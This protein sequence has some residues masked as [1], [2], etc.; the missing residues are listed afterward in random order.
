MQGNLP[1]KTGRSKM[2]PRGWKRVR[3]VKY[4]RSVP[5]S[6]FRRTLGYIFNVWTVSLA[7]VVLLIAFLTATYY[8]FEFSGR[9][10]QKL[11]SG[12]VFTPN[13]G[14]YSAPKTLRSGESTSMPGLIDYLK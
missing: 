8:W 3:R 9:I 7:L 1:I 5:K 11:L 4:D 14:I 13:A 2:P 10:D 12:E 6:R